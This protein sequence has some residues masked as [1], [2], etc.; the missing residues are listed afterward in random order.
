MSARLL[1]LSLLAAA[2]SAF[3]LETRYDPMEGYGTYSARAGLRAGALSG[4]VGTGSYGQNSLL[5]EFDLLTFDEPTIFG[6]LLG[7]EF[8]GAAGARSV[9]KPASVVENP[10]NL[11]SG[12]APAGRVDFEFAYDLVRWKLLWLRQRVM[13][14]GGGG[15]DLN[16]HPWQIMTGGSA[17]RAYPLVGGHFQ[18]GLGDLAIID[19]SYRFL[20][21]QSGS[22][23]IEHRAQLAVAVSFI[24]VGATYT[25]TEFTP[26]ADSTGA[27]SK[28]D[29]TQ[30]AAFAAYAF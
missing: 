15:F 18:T 29:H 22:D 30:F 12:L 20:P 1:L 26:P 16:S 28:G 19:L 5:A 4:S 8:R 11:A 24:T 2:P 13:L 3:A 6:T 25:L 23:S 14:N 27:S 10:D 21:V 17:W 9:E 7:I